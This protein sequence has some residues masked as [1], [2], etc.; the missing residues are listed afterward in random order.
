MI[1]ASL[2]AFCGMVAGALCSVIAGWLIELVSRRVLRAAPFIAPGLALV[3]LIC[4]CLGLFAPIEARLS[5]LLWPPW[6]HVPIHPPP[7]P[8][9]SPCEQ[10]PPTDRPGRQAREL[11]CR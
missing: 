7:Q 3:C 5:M 4:L 10:P 8:Q 11:E 9:R 1:F 2:W 6:Q